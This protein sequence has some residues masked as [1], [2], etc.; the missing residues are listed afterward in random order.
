MAIGAR[1]GGAGL[2]LLAALGLV[3]PANASGT[4][5][6]PTHML[7]VGSMPAPGVAQSLFPLATPW[8]YCMASPTHLARS[9]PVTI[10]FRTAGGGELFH[11]D[12]VPADYPTPLIWAY[13]T[14]PLPAGRYTCR[15]TVANRLYAATAFTVR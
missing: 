2:S 7:S 15:M 6:R 4:A 13:I 12:T 3:V 5:A 14:G 9:T 11:L 10:D 8:I 1:L